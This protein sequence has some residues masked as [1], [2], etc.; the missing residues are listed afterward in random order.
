MTLKKR[1][2]EAADKLIAEVIGDEDIIVACAEVAKEWIKDIGSEYP[3]VSQRRA[4]NVY[5][6]QLLAGVQ[7]NRQEVRR[8]FEM[9]SP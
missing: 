1:H 9:L 3:Q 4:Q 6:S 8:V 2:L 5:G 7:L